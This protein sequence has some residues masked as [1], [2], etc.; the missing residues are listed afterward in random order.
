MPKAYQYMQRNFMEKRRQ[1]PSYL[2]P[3]LFFLLETIMMWLTLS[4]FNLS[5][6]IREWNIYSYPVALLWIIFS[7]V[8]LNIVLKR[9]KMH[10]D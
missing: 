5:F 3:I 6:H 2:I 1:R 7:G 10:Y 9:Q 4:L 8:K